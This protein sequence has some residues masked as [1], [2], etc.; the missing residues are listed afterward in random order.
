VLDDGNNLTEQV[1]QPVEVPAS[2]WPSYSS[3]R[4]PELMRE[5]QDQLNTGEAEGPNPEQPNTT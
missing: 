3:E 4:F 1:A 5:L 2:D